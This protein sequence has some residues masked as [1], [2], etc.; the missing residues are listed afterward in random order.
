[1][2][3]YIPWVPYLHAKELLG[4]IGLLEPL[5]AHNVLVD[6]SRPIVGYPYVAPRA[7]PTFAGLVIV[8]AFALLGLFALA[9]RSGSEP[10]LRVD[11]ENGVAL[12]VPLALATPVGLPLYSLLGSDI[13]D[14]RS[15][16][17]SVPAAALILAALLW[18]LPRPLR[19]LGVAAALATLVFGAIKAITPGYTR[20]PFR[21]TAAY[22]D[23]VAS[24]NDPIIFY[25]TFVDKD[26][27]VHFKR[28]HRVIGSS[29]R[30]WRAVA[31]GQTAYLVI[32]D[33]FAQRLGTGTPHPPGFVLTGRRQ[34]RNHVASFTLLSYR[35]L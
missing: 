8:G 3:L 1:V 19:A 16:D 11:K 15:L 34:Y 5:N 23:S 27:A 31:P 18:A 32:D 22:L 2:L 4:V 25:P 20:P 7:I 12:L 21:A 24:R 9:R 30:Q 33:L 6:L 29:A 35:A 17:A 14:A 28:A 13:W 10:R 26:I